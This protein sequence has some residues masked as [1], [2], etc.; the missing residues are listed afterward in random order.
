MKE[1]IEAKY[2]IDRTCKTCHGK[3]LKDVVLAITVNGKDIT[4][5]FGT[6]TLIED[7]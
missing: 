6:E 7:K 2:M 1:E 3:R 4:E 5:Y